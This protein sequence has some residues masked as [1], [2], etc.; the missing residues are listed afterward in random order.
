[1]FYMHTMLWVSLLN[2]TF[3]VHVYWTYRISRETRHST[4][5]QL[6]PIDTC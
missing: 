4:G 2:V 3:I 1:M 6:R 5:F